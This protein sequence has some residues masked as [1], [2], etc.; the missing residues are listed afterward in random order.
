[1]SKRKI[2]ILAMSLC[3]VAI[4]AVGGTLAYF[5]AE[6]TAVNVFTMGN[7]DI[8]LVEDYEQG[9]ELAPGLK[10]NKDVSVKNTGSKPAYVRLHLAF[11]KDMDDGDPSY[12]AVNN[13]L[14]WNWPSASTA[15]GLWS[16]LPNYSTGNGYQGNGAGKWNFYEE[17]IGGIDYNVYVITY[18]SPLAAGATTPIFLDQIYLDTSVDCK[19]DEATGKF[20]YTDD[21]GNT[22]SLTAEEAQNLKI[23]VAAE[24]TQTDTFENPYDALNTAFGTPGGYDVNWTIE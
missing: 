3:M 21:K 15:D 5:T 14:H 12:A 1:M 10:I 16:V 8:E 6:D 18:R 19:K 4:L 11:R 13:F 24:A 22:V 9:T 7:V 17:T 20:I 2:L 23:L